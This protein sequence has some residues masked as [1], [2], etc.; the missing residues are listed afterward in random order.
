MLTSRSSIL[1]RRWAAYV[2]GTVLVLMRE[3][4]VH[5][6]DGISILVMFGVP[7]MFGTCLPMVDA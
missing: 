7:A 3:L 1:A 6:E 2:A 4:N 5:F